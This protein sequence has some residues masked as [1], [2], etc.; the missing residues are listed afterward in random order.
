L[1][2]HLAAHIGEQRKIEPVLGGKGA[3]RLQI[4]GT[5]AKDRNAKLLEAKNSITE[6]CC[7]HR[8]AIGVVFGVDKDYK[9]PAKQLLWRDLA[10]NVG[11][12]CEVGERLV[13][14]KHL[15]LLS[16]ATPI[17]QCRHSSMLS[18]GHRITHNKEH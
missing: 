11:L 7:F 9:T 14:F 2:N 18:S 10:R 6:F 4:V 1:F 5:Q 13:H 12:Q 8:S 16:N 3:M 17:V 15:D